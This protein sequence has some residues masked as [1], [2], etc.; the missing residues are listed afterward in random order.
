MC[1]DS[2]FGVPFYRSMRNGWIAANNLVKIYLSDGRFIEKYQEFMRDFY[3][4]EQKRANRKASSVGFAEKF[5]KL[6]ASVP[7]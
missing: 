2:A 3:D 7:W 1:G 5:V 4:A 6:S